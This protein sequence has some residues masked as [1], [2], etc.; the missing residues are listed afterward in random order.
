VEK[1]F[2]EQQTFSYLYQDGEHFV[3]MQPQTF[4]QVHV[5]KDVVGD[6]VDYCALAQVTNAQAIAGGNVGWEGGWRYVYPSNSADG[7]TS[8]WPVLAMETAANK[9]G[10]TAPAFVVP[11]LKKWIAYIQDPGSGGCGYD[12]PTNLVDESKTGGLLVQ[13]A[14]AGYT[15]SDSNVQ[16]AIAYLNTSWQNTANSTWFGN[17]GQPYAMW[18]IYKGL[19][20]MIGL[21]VTSAQYITNLHTDPGDVDNPNHGYNWWEDYCEFLVSSQIP[22]GS[23][24]FNAQGTWG[25]YA[26]W[27]DPLSTA[28]YTNI[29]LATE[30]VGPTV[31]EPLTLAA[32]LLGVGGLAGYIRRRRVA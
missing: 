24:G 30:L 6:M 31:P 13:M 9:M 15:L 12:S 21:D 11:E 19:Q 16:A 4:D 25:G 17:F 26:Y 28:W 2:V 27:N 22:L 8:Q 7:S 10:I 32:V 20:G 23:D 1:A 14:Y 5:G 29:L 18:S 3:F